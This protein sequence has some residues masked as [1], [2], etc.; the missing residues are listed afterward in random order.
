LTPDARR[1]VREDLERVR[2]TVGASW[3][4][5]EDRPV[6]LDTPMGPSEVP[7]DRVGFFWVGVTPL[8]AFDMGRTSRAIELSVSD[9]P[10]L[11][12]FP[13]PGPR[14]SVGYVLMLP[15]WCGAFDKFATKAVH[16]DNRTQRYLR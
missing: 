5:P 8:D 1:A 16:V 2:A 4:T 15:A 12:S 14:N 13:L 3:H 7:V 6:L 9:L 10:L 11:G